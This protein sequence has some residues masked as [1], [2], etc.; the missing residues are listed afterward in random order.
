MTIKDKQQEQRVFDRSQID[1]N[2]LNKVFVIKKVFPHGE[3][4]RLLL[5]NDFCVLETEGQLMEKLGLDTN[6]SFVGKS[7]FDIFSEKDKMRLKCLFKQLSYENLIVLSYM[8]LRH[9]YQGVKWASI[10]VKNEKFLDE[11]LG[12]TVVFLDEEDSFATLATDKFDTLYRSFFESYEADLTQIGYT[13]RDDVAQ[14]LYALRV[15]LQNFIILHGYE[16]EIN[17]LKKGLND[18]ISKVTNLSNDLLPGTF[19]HVGFLPAMEDLVFSVRRSG[20][21]LRYKIDQHILDK[22]PELQFCCYRV[23]QTLLLI[24]RK[25]E[26]QYDASLLI[27]VKRNKIN[28]KLIEYKG[29]D[30]NSFQHYPES[31]LHNIRNRIAIYEG[32]LEVN[33]VSD[34][35]QV[36]ITM[37][38]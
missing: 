15:S 19:I 11:Q 16:K 2:F 26:V 14:E 29:A 9:T 32:V 28:I 21:N 12:Y 24:R 3:H 13:L 22:S 18:V 36:V 17:I 5:N 23:V 1:N 7:I 38:N 33:R 10:Y 8:Q 4:G 6:N 34:N 37:Y 30:K 31:V 20:Y 25:N 27:S 35:S